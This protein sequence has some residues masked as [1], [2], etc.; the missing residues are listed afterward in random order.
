M[1]KTSDA[2]VSDAPSLGSS[3]GSLLIVSLAIGVG[4]TMLQSFG[5]MAESAKAELHLSDSALAVIQGVSAAV[6]LVLFSIPIGI[7][8]DRQNRVF[9]MIVMALGWTLGTFLTAIAPDPKVLFLARMLTGIGTTGGLTAVLSLASDYCR[10][11][12]RGRA[13]LLP[14]ISKTAGIGAGFTVAGLLLG[15]AAAHRLPALIHTT[16]WRSAQW[17]LGIASALLILPLLLL[18]EPQRHET[19]AGPS[20]PLKVVL[21]EM[22]SRRRW[23][24][25]LFVGQTTVVM[26]DAAAGIW[27]SPV[28]Q[29]SYHLQPGDFAGWLGALVF[30]TGI[31]GSVIGGLAADAG[32]KSQVRGGLLAG[33]VVAAIIGIPSALF[34]IMPSVVGAAIGVGSL[35]LAGSVTG[36]IASVA[37]TVWLPNELRGL[38]I[39]AFI[40]IA[41][42]IGFGIAPSLVTMVSRSLGGEQHLGAALAIV[43]TIV[44]IVSVVGFAVSMRHAPVADFDSP[45]R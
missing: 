40:T 34:P 31:I 1:V 10:P 41:G 2:Q 4:F 26:A 3:I 22:K 18:R 16:P 37:L 32:Q 35:M 44:S 6:S 38:C 15:A 43:G 42:L 11:D 45:V 7:W 14:N 36:I 27:I 9:I 24:I 21:E 13:L 8:V 39:G 29:R 28:L 19:E 30:V 12:Q 17:V 5:I 23:I 25:P 20:A 33:A